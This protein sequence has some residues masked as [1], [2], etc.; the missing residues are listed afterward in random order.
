ML[1]LQ[2]Y[3][4]SKD[5]MSIF[6]SFES[7]ISFFFPSKC[8]DDVLLFIFRNF[9]VMLSYLEFQDSVEFVSWGHFWVWEYSWPGPLWIL[10][11]PSILYVIS[12]WDSNYPRF[13]SFNCVPYVPYSL[14]FAI[15]FSFHSVTWSRSGFLNLGLTKTLGQIICVLWVTILYII[16]YLSTILAFM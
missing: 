7:R 10:L 4:D 15:L 16:E 6:Y 14:F 9:T 5:L 13:R 2:S 3:K 11:P 1:G 8:I 12:L